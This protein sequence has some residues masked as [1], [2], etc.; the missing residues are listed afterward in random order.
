MKF[1]LTSILLPL[2]MACV[3]LSGGCAATSG[4]FGHSSKQIEK[5][6]NRLTQVQDK[7]EDNS[8]KQIFQAQEFTFGTGFAL[9]QATNKE[10][11]ITVAKEMNNRV[12]NILGLPAL[13]QEKEMINL[14]NGLI[15]N[16]IAAKVEL[17][18]KDKDIISIQHEESVLLAA[19]DKEIQKSVALSKQIALTADSTKQE[20]DKYQGWFGLS[21]VFMGI[22][23]FCTTSFWVLIGIG[24]LFLILRVL[25]TVNPIASA[26]F[27]VV[28]VF[29]SWIINAIK[30]IAP[31]ALTVAK[32]VTSEVYNTTSNALTKIV[33][34]VETV[35][36]RAEGTDKIATIEDLLNEAEKSMSDSD[37][38]LVEQIKIKL[39]WKKSST[40]D[41]ATTVKNN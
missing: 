16:T 11:A 29:F 23:Q 19:Q 10:P 5:Q 6:S 25:S 37:K 2:V 8:K 12:Q 38:A 24:V 40:V 13:E 27:S 22:K 33:D 14:V 15:S 1:K 39:N 18:Q 20:L 21:A 30:V 7:I 34:S 35:Q 31:K 4:F 3:I 28:N 36:L 17:A 26:L 41:V 9:N 32:T